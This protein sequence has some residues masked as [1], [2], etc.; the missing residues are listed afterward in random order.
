MSTDPFMSQSWR[1]KKSRPAGPRVQPRKMSG[2]ACISRWP[3]TTRS[4]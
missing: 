4:P 3:T 2:V 1:K